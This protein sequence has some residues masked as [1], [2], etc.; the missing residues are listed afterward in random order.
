MQGFFWV[1]WVPHAKAQRRNAE[2]DL[3]ADRRALETG[4]AHDHW[5]CWKRPENDE[6]IRQIL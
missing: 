4:S 5:V 3:N 1:F 6:K 2:R